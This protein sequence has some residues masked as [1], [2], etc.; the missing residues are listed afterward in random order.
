MAV[1]KGNVAIKIKID[2]EGNASATIDKTTKSLEKLEKQAGKSGGKVG[3]SMGMAGKEAL[4]FKTGL[5]A[6]TAKLGL[7]SMGVRAATGALKDFG[8]AMMDGA[9]A[10]DRM[11][12]LRKDISGLDGMLADIKKSSQGMFAEADITAAIANFR[13]FKIPL[14]DMAGVLEQVAK[15]SV[16]TGESS[17]QLLDSLTSGIARGSA[18]RLDN[19]GILI[20]EEQITRDYAESLGKTSKE[21]TQA[22]KKAALLSESMRQLEENNVNVDLQNSRTASIERVSNAFGDLWTGIKTGL[23]DAAVGVLEFFGIIPERMTASER[24]A[25]ELNAALERTATNLGGAAAQTVSWEDAI[26]GLVNQIIELNKALGRQVT[27]DEAAKVQAKTLARQRELA[28]ELLR[29]NDALAAARAEYRMIGELAK[30]GLATQEAWADA[31]E[32]LLEAGK[33]LRDVNADV[34]T[35]R[36]D[37]VAKMTEETKQREEAARLEAI[38]LADLQSIAKSQRHLMALQAGSNEIEIQIRDVKREISKLDSKSVADMERM[39]VLL[40]KQRGLNVINAMLK[41]MS[42]GTVKGFA[43]SARRRRGGGRSKPEEET[44]RDILDLERARLES[45][46]KLTLEEEKQLAIAEHNVKLS[47]IERDL[48]KRKISAQK[49]ANIEKQAE[50]RL[51]SDLLAI[52]EKEQAVAEK[53][54]AKSKEFFSAQAA[55]MAEREAM[56]AGLGLGPSEQERQLAAIDA[57]LGAGAITGD[58]AGRLAGSAQQAEDIKA[59]SE[60]YNLLADAATRAASAQDESIAAFGRFAEAVGSN[61][62]QIVDMLAQMEAAM[63]QGG[64]AWVGAV[65]SAIGVAGTLAAAV[66][67]DEQSKAIILGLMETAHAIAAFATEDYVGGAMHSIAAGL[68]FAAAGDKKASA[69]ASSGG[70]SKRPSVARP[71]PGS[72]TKGR[73][74]IN[75]NAPII[76][77]SPGEIAT[78]LNKLSQGN[79][80][81]GFDQAAA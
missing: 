64:K 80:G 23:A 21:L 4:R 7:V 61:G 79:S 51:A 20:K 44:L 74:I 32:R 18:L 66:V 55:A 3:K 81:T 33:S 50:F 75:V 62:E 65:D 49:A 71:P 1:T 60:G 6:V 54:A 11:D 14:D 12:I 22:E 63:S 27:S 70:G 31:D 36:E 41:G 67:A 13:Q 19:L 69:K 56:R 2:G 35:I 34:G 25:I 76:G 45:T 43:A 39:V 72:D 10:G 58:E 78:G 15:T 47:E 29:A 26:P 53:L 68:Y 16:R 77:G 46:G 52:H 17:A 5:G 28:K 57:A 37:V 73:T 24:A 9:K 38:Q 30:R 59:F 40:E 48:A 8:Q 42:K